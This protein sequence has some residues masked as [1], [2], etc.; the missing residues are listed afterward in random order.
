[1]KLD[2]WLFEITPEVSREVKLSPYTVRDVI[3]F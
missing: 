3:L 1:M 2:A